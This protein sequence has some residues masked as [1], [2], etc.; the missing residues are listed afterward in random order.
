MATA[1]PEGNFVKDEAR[2]L[3]PS[4]LKALEIVAINAAGQLITL[5]QPFTADGEWLKDLSVKV[6][7][8]SGKAISSIRISFTLPETRYRGAPVVLAHLR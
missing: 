2:R 4:P 1:C 8:I 7:N 5:G 3:I 6:R